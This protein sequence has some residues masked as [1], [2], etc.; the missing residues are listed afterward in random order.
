M[1]AALKNIG[2]KLLP[3]IVSGVGNLVG[4]LLGGGGDSGGGGTIANITKEV[5][6]P[7]ANI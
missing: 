3:S 2:T 1:W 7:L 4:G 6:T 5:P